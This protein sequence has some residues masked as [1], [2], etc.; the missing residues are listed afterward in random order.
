MRSPAEISFRLRQEVAN[1]LFCWNPP[2]PALA[3]PVS[4]F[5]EL[6][7]PHAIA[8]SLAASSFRVD[9][10]GVVEQILNG[11]IPALGL[12]LTTGHEICWR[13]DYVSGIET[14][15]TYFRRVPYLDVTRAGD[16]KVIWEIN[17]HQHLVALAQETLF[18]DSDPR[19]AAELTRQLESWLDAN[20]FQ[21]G[22]N[23]TSALEVA[24]RALSW[25][26]I[27]HYAGKL[28]PGKLHARFLTSLFQHGLHLEY[29]LS[30]YFSPN[31]HLLGEAL[32]LFVL[33]K[34]LP[35]WPRSQS[36]MQT[37][38]RIVEQEMMRQVRSDG[39]HFEQS[40]YY[41]VYATDMF[42]FYALLAQPGAEF[43]ERLHGMAVYLD[44]LLGPLRKLPMFGDD[45][46]GRFFHPYGD[47]TRWAEETLAAYGVY[48]NI[49]F[50]TPRECADTLALWWFGKPPATTDAR[51]SFPSRLFADSGIASLV[52]GEIQVLVDAGPF[53]PGSAG[54]SHSDTLQ[55]LVR[56]RDRELLIDPATYTYVGDPQWRNRFRGS[57]AHNTVRIDG[58]DQAFPANPFSWQRPHP[59]VEVLRWAE[60]SEQC[61]LQAR[62]RYRDVEHTRS[63]VL[64]KERKLL[65]VTDTIDGQS[66]H[67]VEWFWHPDGLVERVSPNAIRIGPEH[68]LQWEPSL[69]V[70]ISQG[71]EFGWRSP[72]LGVKLPSP[73][74]RL[75]YR[76]PLPVRR[77]TLIDCAAPA[78]FAA[79]SEADGVL[80]YG[81]VRVPTRT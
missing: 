58:A 9:L 67:V 61:E 48:S 47:R 77:I 63:L 70:E 6:P 66:D 81:F 79:F 5:R 38:A 74:V 75:Q 73:V 22:I 3:A 20:P 65:V 11:Q 18:P 31:T 55:I 52:A 16:H 40:A 27:E 35:G 80:H 12:T 10:R 34:L 51:P 60:N 54:H 25:I 57:A 44:H 37:G 23:W 24:F 15:A 33:G 68:V 14:E 32:A 28:L 69:D 56:D 26:W 29:N 62:C 42:L 45:D 71:G 59:A 49:A 72:A 64:L 21:R 53:G 50:S 43:R 30:V 4:P 1:A 78:E 76:G 39:S 17:R 2:L 41:H 36:W 46:G 8:Q 19:A 13:K 7:D